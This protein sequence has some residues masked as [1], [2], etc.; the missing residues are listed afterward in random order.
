MF[1]WFDLIAPI[2][3]SLIAAALGLWAIARM[4]EQNRIIPIVITAGTIAVFLVSIPWIYVTRYN[5]L[6]VDYKTSR[7]L[8]VIQG[9]INK[10]EK[11]TIEIWESTVIKDWEPYYKNS[12]SVLNGKKLICK[13]VE[14]I[15]LT[16]FSRWVHGYAIDNVMVIGWKNI[17]HAHSLFNHEAAHFMLAAMGYPMDNAT[18]HQLMKQYKLGN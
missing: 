10:C 4:I 17:D 6:K 13:D 18:H 5:S 11:A 7:G 16:S 3:T 8:G 14:D 9:K 12:A 1:S 2:G 15:E